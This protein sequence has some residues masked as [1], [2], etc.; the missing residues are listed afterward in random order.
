LCRESEGS[1]LTDGLLR[2]SAIVPLF[3]A[4]FIAL[5]IGLGRFMAVRL[6]P[7]GV[8]VGSK[9]F[10]SWNEIDEVKPYWVYGIRMLR[11]EN[12]GDATHAV[13]ALHIDDLQALRDYVVANA[14]P[15]HPMALWLSEQSKAA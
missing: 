13:I 4:G 11:L 8:V 5:C 12:S 7:R 9:R 3:F 10:M 6:T 15:T 2:F 14:G 1:K